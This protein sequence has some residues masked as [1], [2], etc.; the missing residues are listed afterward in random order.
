MISVRVD[1]KNSQTHH[2]DVNQGNILSSVISQ[3]DQF[4]QSFSNLLEQVKKIIKNMNWEDH[5]YQSLL[6]SIFTIFQHVA[7]IYSAYGL[8]KWPGE[9]Q[10]RDLLNRL[11][12]MIGVRLENLQRRILDAFH[13]HTRISAT[14]RLTMAMTYNPLVRKARI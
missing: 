13:L 2:V 14:G 11:R 3:L 7:N 8:L 1:E 9:L 4:A 6:S 12:V 10:D 5:D